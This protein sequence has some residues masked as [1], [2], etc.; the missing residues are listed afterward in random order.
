MKT[1]DGYEVAEMLAHSETLYQ[2]LLTEKPDYSHENICP[3][4]N[5]ALSAGRVTGK[6]RDES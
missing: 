6:A 5:A 1:Y 3:L 2:K 4:C